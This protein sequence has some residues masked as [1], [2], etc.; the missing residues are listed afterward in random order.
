MCVEAESIIQ[1]NKRMRGEEESAQH[2]TAAY[3]HGDNKDGKPPT[4]D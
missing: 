3:H 1:N 4:E 2:A